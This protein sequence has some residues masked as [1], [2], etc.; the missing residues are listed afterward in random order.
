MISEYK[1]SVWLQ[2]AISTINKR[3]ETKYL[4]KN[5]KTLEGIFQIF[6]FFVFVQHVTFSTSRMSAKYFNIIV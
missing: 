5:R 1:K 3:F 6:Q 2:A 4:F